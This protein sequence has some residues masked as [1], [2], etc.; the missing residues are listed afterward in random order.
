M[1][2][3][4]TKAKLDEIRK[5]GYRPGIVGA[6]INKKKI[7][8]FFKQEYRL[9]MLPQG[10]IETN[11]EIYETLQRELTEE[12]GADLVGDNL[13]NCTLV[14]YEKLLFHETKHGE[15]KLKT[16]DGSEIDM[17]GKSYFF[18]T[19]QTDKTKLD[20]NKVDFDDYCWADYKTAKYL[21]KI[22]NIRKKAQI[23]DSFLDILKKKG[24]VQ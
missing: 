11:E 22:M 9:W 18:Y 3:I 1:M 2:D 21:V 15:K 8:F 10:G 16:Q 19:I 6:F 4:P 13:K 12:V 24:V 23:M 17:I 14:F 20:I 5:E 7:L